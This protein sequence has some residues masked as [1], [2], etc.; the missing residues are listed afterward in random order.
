MKKT[1]NIALSAIL[2]AGLFTACTK[3][4]TS[5][6][7]G[8]LVALNKS[9]APVPSSDNWELMPGTGIDIGIGSDAH[10]VIFA[11]NTTLVTSTGGNQVVKWDSVNSTWN[12]VSGG[13][14]IRITVDASGNPWVVNKSNLIYKYNGSTWTQMPG[15]GTDIGIS[16]T[17]GSVYAINTTLVTSTGGYQV[18]KWNTTTSGWDVVPGGAGV[19]IA[20]DGSGMP[21]VVNKS[22]LIFKYNG[23]TWTQLPGTATDIGIGADGTAYIVG[24]T[25]VSQTGGYRISKW[26]GSGWTDTASGAGVNIAVDWMGHPWATNAS[27]L[28]YRNLNI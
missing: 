19:R 21:W 26:N 3:E 22:N 2:I 12:P 5:P 6:S 24:T 9:L 11:I 15:T 23:N 17:N 7:K 18:V 13:A 10:H 27:N 14:G 16:S 25:L 28:I 8:S 1:L 20:V 4:N